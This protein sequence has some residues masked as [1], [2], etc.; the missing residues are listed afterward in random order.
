MFVAWFVA[1]ISTKWKLSLLKRLGA[2][3][4]QNKEKNAY[5]RSV[6]AAF[7]WLALCQWAGSCYSLFLLIT[8]INV[9]QSFLLIGTLLFF[10]PPCPCKLLLEFQC[11]IFCFLSAFSKSQ[12]SLL[13][14][15][16]QQYS[17]PGSTGLSHRNTL[18]VNYSWKNNPRSPDS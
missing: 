5:W 13:V 3:Y 9:L 6:K 14:L 1:C 17:G 4:L 2:I 15:A 12:I 16:C 10:F 11:I 8:F 7:L 18:D